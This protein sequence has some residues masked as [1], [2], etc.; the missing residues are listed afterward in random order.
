MRAAPVHPARRRARVVLRA[1][2]THGGEPAHRLPVG[3]RAGV[4]R[5]S[6]STSPITVTTTRAW[7]SRCTGRRARRCCSPP[8]TSCSATDADKED[9]DIGAVYWQQALITTG[10]TALA[11][12][13]AWILVGPWAGVLAGA[14]VG[15]YPPLI[16]A[17]GDQLS[18][19]LGAFL[20]LAAFV[21]LA[22]AVK[23]RARWWGWAIAGALFALAILT[24]TDLLP[25]PFLIAGIGG[26]VVLFKQRSLRPALLTLGD[27]GDRGGGRAGA[28]D[29]LCLQRGRQA[30]PGDPGQRG[31]AVRRHL[32]ARRRHD[33]RHEGA[34][35]AA[36]ARPP[37]GVRRDEDVQ[38]PGRRRSRDLRRAPSGSVAQRGA[39]AR[40]AQE[41]HPLLD[42]AAGRVRE[43][44]V[45]EGQADV[46]LLLPR[47]WRALHLDADADL[48]GVPR[49]R[50]RRGPARGPHPPPRPGSGRRPDRDRRTRP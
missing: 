6:R 43:D 2:R 32:P 4:R 1:Q 45:G 46:V 9:F 26:L 5:S 49:A 10:T 11:A 22:L 19:P 28:V 47:R 21:A 25:V 13:L 17:T 33:D 27:G 7:R 41:P 29:D 35:R 40:G 31:G 24:R 48:A 12:A 44:A 30:R 36:V 34:P 15:T 3:G 23:R 14:I 37:P 42:D 16:G 18:E 8:R 39:P 20:L 38:D 50:L